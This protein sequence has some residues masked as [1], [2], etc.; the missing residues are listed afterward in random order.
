LIEI[1]LV[2][3]VKEQVRE[4]RMGRHLET[5]WQ[6]VSYA[7][8]SL[9]KHAMLS[10]II[11]ATLTLGIGVSAGVFTY[12]NAE[13]LRARLYK[14][15]DS[16]AKVYSAYTTDP[17]RP[18]AWGETTLE[19]YLAFRDGAKS[20]RNLAAYADFYAPLGKDDPVG[21][22]SLL[23]TSNFFSLYD[24]R[25]PLMG[26]L[27]QPED[28][29]GAKPVVV[30]GERLWRNRFAADPQI[31]GKIAH[32][33]GQPVTV[34]GVAPT[35]AGMVNGATAWLPYTLETYL[36]GGDNL[37]R[38]GDAAWLQVVGRLN[39]GFSHGDAVAELKLLAGQQDR[40]HPGRTTTLTVTNGSVIQHPTGTNREANRLLFALILGTL[41]FIVL[42]VCV[43][44]TTLLLSRSA[45]RRQEIAVRLALGASR[46][47]LIRMLLTETFL[48][49]AL[50]G[51]LSF[52]LA[53]KL[54]DI[55]M[56][57]LNPVDELGAWS[58]APDWR[59]FVFLTLMTVLAGTTAGLQPAL[60]SLRVNL[61][62][63]LKG[64]QSSLGGGKG[65]W[66][67]GQ[68]IAA[69]VAFS[70]FLLCGAILF[71]SV[72]RQ[73]ANFEPG[74]ETRQVLWADLFLRSRS[75]EPRNWGD[76]HRRLTER[77]AALPGAQ[78]VAYSNRPFR[79]VWIDDVH[80]PGQALRRV[81]I[82][83]VSSNYFTTLGI[84]IVNGRAFQESDPPCGKAICPVV[85]SQRLANAFWPGE[86][87][88][89]HTVRNSAGRSFEVVGVARDISSRRLGDL[90][91]PT[92]YQ[93]A[94]LNGNFPAQPLVRFSGDGEAL[95]R[96][97]AAAAREL[98]PELSV[99]ARTIQ[100]AREVETERLWRYARLI[101]L[102]CTM[103]VMLAILGIYG[104]VTF[105]VNRR[106]KEMGIR[107][108]LGAQ[109][110]DIYHAVLRSSGRPV[111]I[112]LLIGLAVTAATASSV[113]PLSRN[114]GF[115]VNAMDPGA[116]VITAM[117]LAGVSLSAMLVPA[118][119][120]TRVDP[121]TV[122][123]DE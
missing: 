56:R 118:R 66:L 41:I 109:N 20:L 21:V 40:L 88:L 113:A 119:R 4:V 68:L 74:F 64:R 79:G 58:L 18:G 38:P 43:N 72:A 50:A 46:A 101:V 62:E 107:I 25:Q 103:S 2:D 6:D 9:R 65:S 1:G 69:Q 63:T 78:S 48:L 16:F 114:V 57:W 80:A 111:V 117:L 52:Y 96:A 37:L 24:L 35:F 39:P 47:R 93:P 106:T 51:I 5:L 84:A 86:N 23:V 55:L 90:D 100:S 110:K 104:V 49:A 60:Q 45:A 15:F 123:R 29:A 116:Y 112:G 27:L 30:L 99:E 36:K 54:P 28:Y 8:S 97:V 121:M 7:A 75:V 105:A 98:A 12:Y 19:D 71:V 14:D 22:R 11:I 26:R 115:T 17:R 91:D 32:F 83:L 120:A 73:A 33:N 122:L 108:A 89:G 81:E 76:F 31:L 102:V 3:Q 92:I 70:F 53:Y 67:Y 10:I 95:T 82:N 59:V 87:P 85:V 44:V 61:S 94:N 34:V 77:L 13:F 42:I